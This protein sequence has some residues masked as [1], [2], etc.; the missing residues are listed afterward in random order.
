MNS[1]SLRGNGDGATPSPSAASYPLPAYLQF[2]PGG[3]QYEK[4]AAAESHYYNLHTVVDPNS[5]IDRAAQCDVQFNSSRVGCGA[6]GTT[7]TPTLFPSL[8]VLTEAILHPLTGLPATQVRMWLDSILVH[9]A[10]LDESTRSILATLDEQ[11]QTSHHTPVHRRSNSSGS[12]SGRSYS[13]SSSVGSAASMGAN[14]PMATSPLAGSS[15]SDKNNATQLLQS[16]M[17]HLKEST[18]STDGPRP[19]GYVFRRG[20]IAW[21]CRTCQTDSTCVLCDKCFHASNHEGHEVFFHRTTPGGCCDCGD[22]EAWRAEGCCPTHRPRGATGAS[23]AFNNA[24]STLQSGGSMDS[25]NAEENGTAPAQEFE[26]VR[27]AAR[28]KEMTQESM[29]RLPPA[30]RSALGVVIGAAVQCVL[31]A[32]DGCGVG[33]DLSQWRLRWSEQIASLVNGV[34]HEEEY[35][36]L[37]HPKHNLLTPQAALE[38]ASQVRPPQSN[39]G[40]VVM[41][42]GS[43]E[44]DAQF[45]PQIHLARSGDSSAGLL[46]P[47]QQRLQQHLPSSSAKAAIPAEWEGTFPDKFKL[48]LRLHN[49]D[50]HTFDEVIDALLRPGPSRRTNS[51]EAPSTPL[52]QNDNEAESMTHHVDTDGQV[53]VSSFDSLP[54]CVAGFTRLKQ[55]GLLCSAVSTPQL[56]LELR[57]RAILKWLTDLVKLHPALS[58]IV[59]H[60]LVDVTGG[61][62]DFDSLCQVWPEARMLCPW[63]NDIPQRGPPISPILYTREALRKKWLLQ[64]QQSRG[65]QPPS[66]FYSNVPCHLPSGKLYKS[67]HALWGTLLSPNEYT[68]T[69]SSNHYYIIDTDLRKQQE[70]ATLTSALY[71]HRLAGLNLVSGVSLLQEGYVNLDGTIVSGVEPDARSNLIS[72]MLTL[73]YKEL[74]PV[75]SKST[76]VAPVSPLM[77]M[78]LLDPYPTKQFRTVMHNLWLNL[79]VD[80]R[81]K[82]RF[83]A[84]LGGV[85]YRSLTTLFCAGVGTELDSPLTFT[86]QI[87]TVK[88]L[89]NALNANCVTKLLLECD[90]SPRPGVAASS[91]PA[92]A[93]NSNLVGIGGSVFPA[94]PTGGGMIDTRSLPI[95]TCIVR[96]LHTNIVGSTKEVQMLIEHTG[97]GRADTS[98][99]QHMGGTSSPN[100]YLPALVYQHGE[101]PATEILPAAPDDIFLECRTTRHKRLPHLIRDLE[102]V[103]ETQGTALSLLLRR[104]ASFGG[105]ESS[106][107]NVPVMDFSA[108]FARLLRLLQGMDL[109]KRKI[110]GGHVE[111]EE[112]RWLEAFA[113]SLNFAGCRDALVESP[114]LLHSPDLASVRIGMGNMF[115]S[116]LREIKLYLFRED[117]LDNGLLPANYQSRAG[118][119]NQ[120]ALQRSTL[121]VPSVRTSSL[122]SESNMGKDV[123]LACATGVKMSET[124]LCMIEHALRQE[125]GMPHVEGAIGAPGSPNN[126]RGL[127]GRV[128]GVMMGDWLKVPHQPLS[129]DPLSF[130]LPLHRALA[131]TIMSL[132]CIP[133]PESERVRY[134][135]SWWKLQVLDGAGV[136]HSLTTGPRG[137]ATPQSYLAELL[138][139]T[140]RSGNCKIVWQL[141]DTSPEHV[142]MRKHRQY[143]ISSDIAAIKVIHSLADL[144]IRCLAASSQIER[145]LW[146]KNGSSAAGM[147]LNYTSVPLCKSFRD[148]DLALVQFSASGFEIGLGARRVL[149]LLLS[150]YSIEGY[151]KDPE[152]QRKDSASSRRS[153]S[154]WKQP[155]RLSDPDQAQ[156]LAESLFA[157]LCILV[158]ELPPPPPLSSARDS[159]GTDGHVSLVMR[160]E[161][162]HALAAEPKSYSEAFSSALSGISRRDTAPTSSPGGSGGNAGDASSSTSLRSIFS[163]VLRSIARE[164][165]NSNPSAGA[166]VFELSSACSDEYDPTFYH[167]RRMEHQHAMDV[168]ARLR[169]LKCKD[170]AK[171]SPSSTNS[172]S[173]S[174][175]RRSSSKVK[176]NPVLP[177]V[178]PPP[179]AHPR[180]L[181]A[182]LILHLPTMDAAIRRKLLFALFGGE[183]LPPLQP[184][185]T[186]ENA[187][188]PPS[189]SMSG[190]GDAGA[191]SG[192]EASTDDAWPPSSGGQSPAEAGNAAALLRIRAAGQPPRKSSKSRPD[193]GPKTVQQ[194]SVSSLEVLQLLTLQ[195]HTLESMATL[196]RSPL[197]DSLD[198]EAKELSKSLDVNH[199]LA[200]MIHVPESLHGAWAIDAQ[201]GPL[202]SAGNGQC[203]GSILGV[204]IA[205]WE[206]S[207]SGLSE[208]DDKG[209]ESGDSSSG[210]LSSSGGARALAADGLKWILRFVA[211]LVDG[212]SSIKDAA[213]AA[214]EGIN[215]S[216]RKQQG[217]GVSAS[218]LL[219]QDLR[220]VIQGMFSDVSKLWPEAQTPTDTTMSPS[221]NK[222]GNMAGSDQ[223]NMVVSPKGNGDPS[224]A[225]TPTQDGDQPSDD[226]KVKLAA[227]KSAQKAAL[228]KMRKQQAIFAASLGGATAKDASESKESSMDV[229]LADDEEEDADECIICRCGA[230]DSDSPLGYLGHVQRSRTLALRH[231]SELTC[232]ETSSLQEDG[233]SSAS[234]SVLQIGQCARVVGD[235]GCQLRAAP[236]MDSAP[237]ACLP[238]GSVVLILN[239]KVS[240]KYDLRARRVLVRHIPSREEASNNIT[241]IEGWASI[242]SSQGYVILAALADLGWNRW[243]TTRPVLRLCGHAAHLGCVDAHC[244]SLQQRADGDHPYDG[245]F[246]ANIE[247]GEFLCPL[248]K[249]LSNVLLPQYHGPKQKKSTAPLNGNVEHMPIVEWIGTLKSKLLTLDRAASLDSGRG[250][251]VTKDRDAATRFSS[252]LYQSMQVS[253]DKSKKKTPWPDELDKWDYE[254]K[255]Q[256]T[257]GDI[258]DSEEASPKKLQIGTALQHMRELHIS[259]ALLGH[260]PALAEASARFK[261]PSQSS[262]PQPNASL[263]SLGGGSTSATNSDEATKEGGG[264]TV[265]DPWSGFDKSNRDTHTQLVDMRRMFHATCGVFDVV[266]VALG[267]MERA[268]DTDQDENKA[269][270]HGVAT[271]GLLLADI[272]DGWNGGLAALLDPTLFKQQNSPQGMENWKL[273]T[274]YLA[275]IPMHVA[276]DGLLTPRSLARSNSAAMWVVRGCPTR[277]EALDDKPPV[278]L[279]SAP[280]PLSAQKVYERLSA[281]NKANVLERVGS[282]KATEYLSNRQSEKASDQCVPPPFLPAL[283][284]GFL[285]MPLLSWDLHTFSAAIFSFLLHNGQDT[286]CDDLARTAQALVMARLVQVLITPNGYSKVPTNQDFAMA[287]DWRETLPTFTKEMRG[288]ETQSLLQFEDMCRKSI[289]YQGSGKYTGE[290]KTGS[291]AALD[292]VCAAILP[293]VRSVVLLLRAGFSILRARKKSSSNPSDFEEDISDVLEHA[294]TMT[295][296]DALR[297]MRGLGCP[298][299]S[300]LVS[301][302]EGGADGWLP[303]IERWLA[304]VASLESH[305]GSRGQSVYFDPV[306]R[307]PVPSYAINTLPIF[308]DDSI[309]EDEEQTDNKAVPNSQGISDSGSDL[310][311]TATR[312]RKQ[313]EE[314]LEDPEAFDESTSEWMELNDPRED[315][316]AEDAEEVETDGEDEN[317]MMQDPNM[318]GAVAVFAP[319]FAEMDEQESED[320]EMMDDAGEGNAF[321]VLSRRA[322][323]PSATDSKDDD[324]TADNSETKSDDFFADVAHAAI[325][326]YQPSLLAEDVLGPGPRGASFDCSIASKLLYE[327]SHLSLI[328]REGSA[329]TGLATMPKSFVELYGLV[330]KVKSDATDENDESATSET[331]ICLLTGAIMKSGSTRRNSRSHMRPPGAC[332]MHARKVGSGIGVFF[333]VQKCTVLLMHNN[334]SAYSP[335]LYVDENGE[336]DPGLRRGRPLYLNQSRLQSLEALWRNNGVPRE[337]AQIRSTSDRVIRDN[338]Y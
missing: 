75:L 220:Q 198:P 116:L 298:L 263:W 61:E 315:G 163:H 35:S 102:Y 135:E 79:L 253:W 19:C 127:D 309:D 10:G 132:C 92:A 68:A 66:D 24:D 186:L 60:A 288:K 153:A 289:F 260:A 195:I 146:A 40:E 318:R 175:T 122:V 88:S 327:M 106:S 228:D 328:H 236:A 313:T 192:G 125:Y 191:S 219:S 31:K 179:E 76:F 321:F 104:Y 290:A 273:L 44:E 93:G 123:A 319:S 264:S 152:L 306:S 322:A 55:C 18:M 242:Q 317:L 15:L 215:I 229:S 160:R 197:K 129:G 73:P 141:P 323:S 277:D 188:A 162:L 103:F 314:M 139:P 172:G 51:S 58:G 168:I 150:R 275:S 105:S 72:T 47:L 25:I 176:F 266:S 126:N 173:G 119:A 36:L 225:V 246:A 271:I 233:T 140:L 156:V 49:D 247:E 67:P 169:H 39:V 17:T 107:A 130:H 87:F 174:P 320:E 62:D 207:Y 304:S 235:R 26:A 205:L 7:H 16:L 212:A 295:C 5:L 70:T 110:S 301:S 267:N 33:A 286:Q 99:Q 203:R 134:P 90:A 299:P 240:P 159:T 294:S 108:A 284:S 296:N 217:P 38:R 151:L 81:F 112:S 283:A 161:L 20:D 239:S 189:L 331:A 136:E 206:H 209:K 11:L 56:D 218:W 193:F 204:L 281:K 334:K 155:P 131:K 41:P 144:P 46:S 65:Q 213:R 259:W 138:V 302:V 337:V 310:A 230:Q 214:T 335:S 237:V 12:G 261:S 256:E 332:T 177:L 165:P 269:S 121:H 95:A 234:S 96:V 262:M 9:Y 170:I 171:S 154:K 241:A 276:R 21:N 89:V 202:P 305:H 297:V 279:E 221:P 312:S 59:V 54:A 22:V 64:S 77:L 222:A 120:E 45:P 183:W 111:Y 23:G 8:S 307:K 303:V 143:Q 71:P 243:G 336:E 223:R 57:A 268:S 194:S 13:R 149:S 83:A 52:V 53:T 101:H 32:A 1:D 86:V 145:H 178:P 30:L 325:I 254:E 100:G 2:T 180:F 196:H 311:L 109:Q 115:A 63:E 78:L 69:S 210:D 255:L 80:A 232:Q 187:S 324:E 285:Y 128:R 265:T 292:A 43:L 278:I 184:V 133:V 148:L 82:S 182:R 291:S 248:C 142:H 185:P 94:S 157:L 114:T 274:A 250:E 224:S 98:P 137:G 231:Q 244:A 245:R 147:A 190:S 14:S 238:M 117:L 326:P 113:L 34:A 50:V 166:P 124:Q 158:T 333:L 258:E 199:Y 29:L 249:Q 308:G 251:L 252:Q 316:D 4:S 85:A 201:N 227:R 97:Q 280:M 270:N 200:R 300:E 118:L 48:H 226:F 74:H 28:A 27:A 272:L 216:Q 84:S 208:T 167:L 42:S 338:W 287:D 330:N 91:A 181:S 3:I 282:L 293:F 37:S 257:S 164:R 6:T 211:S 329:G